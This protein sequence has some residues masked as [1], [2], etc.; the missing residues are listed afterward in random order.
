MAG[1]PGRRCG[2]VH[3]RLSFGGEGTDLRGR[4]RIWVATDVMTELRDLENRIDVRAAPISPM[5]PSRAVN[6]PEGLWEALEPAVKQSDARFATER[7]PVPHMSVATRAQGAGLPTVARAIADVVPVTV[8][9]DRAALVDSST[10]ETCRAAH[11][12]RGSA[13]RNPS[14]KGQAGLRWRNAST[15]FRTEVPRDCNSHALST[16]RWLRADSRTRASAW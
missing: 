16:P 9:V 7:A 13:L 11:P 3:W 14:M 15:R 10:G 1:T 6:R 4:N 2:A 8:R 12:L 5:A